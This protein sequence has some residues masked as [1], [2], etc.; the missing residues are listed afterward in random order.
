M[1]KS[2]H[3][4]KIIRQARL[5]PNESP[6]ATNNDVNVVRKQAPRYLPKP[7]S[8]L[9]EGMSYSLVSRLPTSS[10]KGTNALHLTIFDVLHRTALYDKGRLPSNDEKELV[11]QQIVAIPEVGR[12]YT[13]KAHSNFCTRRQRGRATELT[14]RCE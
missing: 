4:T 2:Q 5:A 13:R 14:W 12:K 3:T 8:D 7:A 10:V 1:P 6:D 9:R 11:Y